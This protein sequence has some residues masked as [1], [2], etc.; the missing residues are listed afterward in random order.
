MRAPQTKG[1]E[2]EMLLGVQLSTRQYVSVQQQGDGIDTGLGLVSDRLS[3]MSCLYQFDSC[4]LFF[5]YCEV[6]VWPCGPYTL[7]ASTAA[8][9]GFE[10]PGAR[11][12]LCGRFKRVRSED[13]ANPR[14][15]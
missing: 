4:C 3:V 9:D 15:R 14:G 10:E 1:A 2:V 12:C 5:L 6:D 8:D 11:P 7:S 13:V